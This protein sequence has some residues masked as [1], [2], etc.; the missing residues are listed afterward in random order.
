MLISVDREVREISEAIAMLVLSLK[1]AINCS[2]ISLSDRSKGLVL[3]VATEARI[4]AS[5]SLPNCLALAK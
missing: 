2:S 4:L 5:A 1:S 3:K